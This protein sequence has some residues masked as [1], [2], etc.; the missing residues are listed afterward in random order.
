MDHE[1]YGRSTRSS[2]NA[3]IV[4]G[5]EDL[6]A[7]VVEYLADLELK[8]GDQVPTGTYRDLT[9]NLP[10]VDPVK[11]LAPVLLVRASMMASPSTTC[12]ISSNAYQ[13]AIAS[14]S[15]CP[16]WRTQWCPV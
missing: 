9:A 6:K 15:Y 5:V 7:A 4:S 10:V 14:S 12:P 1:N 16:A 11:V 2:A 8:F 3:D 13:T